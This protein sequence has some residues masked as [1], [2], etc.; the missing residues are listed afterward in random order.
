MTPQFPG[1]ERINAHAIIE[2]SVP[3][4]ALRD[5]A[6]RSLGGDL[7]AAATAILDQCYEGAEANRR[8]LPAVVN[9]AAHGNDQVL[10]E[11]R[12]SAGKRAAQILAD[13]LYTVLRFS[14]GAR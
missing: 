1:F 9:A 2:R 4:F 7:R 12:L 8:D 11:Y 6:P 13:A 5:R 14:D 3:E 10:N